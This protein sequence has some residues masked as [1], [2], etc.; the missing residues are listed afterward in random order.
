[1]RIYHFILDHRVGGPHGYVRSIVQILAYGATS[2]LV[3]TGR[4]EVTDLALTNLRHYFRGLYPLEVIWNVLSLCWCF[5]DKNSRKRCIFDVHGAANVAPLF[6][7]R[8]LGIPVVWHFHETLGKFRALV[9]LGK[10]TLTG[11]TH[12]FVVVAKKSAEVF[13][14]RNAELIPGAVDANFWRVS[15]SERGSREQGK[16]LRL[17]T[18]GNLNPLKGADI[19][20]EALDGVNTPWELVIVGAELRTF[21]QYA[22]RLRD[23]ADKMRRHDRRIE[24]AGWQPAEVVRSFLS[25]ANIF[26]LPSRSEACPIALLEAM[27]TECACVATNV[28][29]VGEI[30]YEPGVG[31]VT[32]SE[33][34]D[35]LREALEHVAS[36]GPEGR[37]EMGTRA[38]KNVVERY[39]QQMMAE[40]HLEIYKKLLR[41]A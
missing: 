16:N 13:R 11:S 32:A 9:W 36:I 1:M 6:A 19:L 8:L 20:L 14:L 10:T 28:G 4:G 31:I 33:S 21:G 18:V 22:A 38:R 27:A 23:R 7:A 26:V 3:T 34:P 29:D 2:I 25:S 41:E 40:R 24:F 12:R 15:E 35:R 39:S 37:R 30:L 5:K 17:V